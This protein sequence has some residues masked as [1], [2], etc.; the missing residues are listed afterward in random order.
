[1]YLLIKRLLLGLDITLE[2]QQLLFVLGESA[3]SVLQ[4]VVVLLLKG[5]YP[6]VFLRQLM[7]KVSFNLC[8]LVLEG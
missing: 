3:I 8:L 2:C 6:I 7:C 1:M 5:L 4:E